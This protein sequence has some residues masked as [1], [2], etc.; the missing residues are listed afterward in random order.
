M[1]RHGTED[2]EVRLQVLAERHDAGDV[3]AAVAIVGRR[4][5]GYHVL[6]L[7]VVLVAL[8]DELMRAGNEGQ[9]VYVVELEKTIRLAGIM[10]CERRECDGTYLR[11]DFV[12]EQPSRPSGRNSP[13]IHFLGITPD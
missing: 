2:L 8:V 13:G 11:A 3:A 7:E 5:D 6:G 9:V 12:P 1:I 10:W 4:P